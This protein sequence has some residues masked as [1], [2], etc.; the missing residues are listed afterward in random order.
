MSC[1]YIAKKEAEEEQE[2]EEGEKERERKDV[3]SSPL[4]PQQISAPLLCTTPVQR[5]NRSDGI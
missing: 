5:R 1:Q 3:P 4:P 2:E